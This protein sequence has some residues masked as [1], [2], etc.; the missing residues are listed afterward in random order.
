[1]SVHRF[2]KDGA[3]GLR[4]EEGAAEDPV[5]EWGDA[6]RIPA[7]ISNEMWAPPAEVF[8]RACDVL[9]VAAQPIVSWPARSL[10]GYEM[11]LRSADSVL[12]NPRLLVEAAERI[13]RLKELGRKARAEVAR[14]ASAAPE[15]AL[16][17]INMHPRDLLDDELCGGQDELGAYAHRCVLEI[18]E[19]VSL[20]EIADAR[21]RIQ[22]LRIIGYHVAVGNVGSGYG[23]L[24][25]V[26]ELE[27]DTVKLDIHLIRNLHQEPIRRR[28]VAAL[29]TAC[30]DLGLTAVAEGIE[31]AGERDAL[32]DLGCELMQ[33]YLF[34][35]PARGF[36][37]PHWES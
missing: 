19:R 23:G 15:G 5:E 32:A 9:W 14:V 26:A 16:L 28:L 13:G 7:T 35:R 27:P 10:F 36:P 37:E 31:V 1:M 3:V 20:D 11:F 34:G 17:F 2:V 30:R 4:E 6:Q 21:A 24:A 29:L 18:T 33:G 22:Q 25:S 12:S 8:Q